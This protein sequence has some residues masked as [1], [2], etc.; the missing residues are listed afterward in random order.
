MKDILHNHTLQP[1]IKNNVENIELKSVF[2]LGG[3]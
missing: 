1:T 3:D 2:F